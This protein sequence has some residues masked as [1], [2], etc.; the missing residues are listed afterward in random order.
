MKD[1]PK[2]NLDKNEKVI[3]DKI[4]CNGCGSKSIEGIRY[5]CAICKNFDYCEKCFRENSEKHNHPFIKFYHQYMKLES[6]KV[7]INDNDYKEKQEETKKENGKP[8]HFNIICDGCNKGPSVGCRYKCAVCKDFDYC[9][10]CEEKLSKTHPHPFIKIYK[11]EMQLLNIDCFF[12][13]KQNKK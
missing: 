6:I 2:K 5:K 9:E 4:N 13:N 12:N 8:I 10:E 11:P 3:F 7:V 1:S